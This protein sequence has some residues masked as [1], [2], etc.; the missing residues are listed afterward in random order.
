[1]TMARANLVDVSVTRW[2][3]C[4]TRCVA[5]PCSWAKVPPTV[6]RRLQAARPRTCAAW[7]AQS[8]QS[9]TAVAT[10][11]ILPNLSTLRRSSVCSAPPTHFGLKLSP[12]SSP[13]SRPNWG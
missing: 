12:R 6:S 7:S 11:L 8:E 10:A 2:Y 4:V 3:H 5:G 9:R 13:R 1:M